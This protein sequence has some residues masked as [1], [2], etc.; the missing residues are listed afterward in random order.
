MISPGRV[1]EVVRKEFR[2]VF[3][4]PRMWR[5]VFVA[6][7][8]QLI[9]F[10]YAVSTDVRDTPTFVVDASRT[11]ESRELLD[12]FTAP[13]YFRVVG[14]SDRIGDVVRM[15]DHGDAL[16]GVVIP[17]DFAT[18]LRDGRGAAVQLLLDGTQSNTALVAQGYAERIVQDYAARV[19]GGVTLAVELRERAWFNPDLASRNYNVPAVA[20]AI[21]FL[22]CLLLTSL[23]VVREREIG[24]LEQLMV[25]PLSG[26]ELIAGKT[27]PFALIG[28]ADVAL[29][30]A[31]ALLWFDVPFAGSFALLLL[32]SLLFILSGLGVGLL[33]SS[34]SKTQQEAFMTTFLIFMP[35]ILLSGLMF[36]VSSMPEFF[37][38]ATLANP[39]RHYLEIVRGIFLKG[40]GLQPLWMQY[41]ALA[42]LGVGILAFA[43]TRFHKRIA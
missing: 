35:T 33:V 41:A 43:T 17:V 24:T 38:W 37:Q 15:L 22:V 34:V 32:A 14:R 31:A 40:A 13:G 36:P 20:G 23:A 4:D 25:S 5:V 10:G 29:V 28:L 16:V 1:W 2:Q 21:I 42:A 3:R 19:A 30:T 8:I 7:V 27:I 26:P 6:P 11:P 9:V 12:A 39:M 18:R